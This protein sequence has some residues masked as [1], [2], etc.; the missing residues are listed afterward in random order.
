VIRSQDIINLW[1]MS[2]KLLAETQ[3]S[4]TIE[5]MRSYELI[6]ER[7]ETLCRAC[8]GMDLGPTIRAYI[9]NGWISEA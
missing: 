6:M 2:G 8:H 4:F 9:Q 7:L 3:R 1:D 5:G